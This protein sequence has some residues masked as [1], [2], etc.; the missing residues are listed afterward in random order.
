MNKYP[1]VT[2]NERTLGPYFEG[3]VFVWDIDKTYLDTHF[4]SLK[5]LS[6][7]PIEFAQDKKSV[8]GMPEILRGL[9]R[10]GEAGIACHPLYFVSASP[11]LLRSV[12]EHKMQLDGVEYDGF[13]FKDWP[14]ILRRLQPWRL[15]H[16][17]GF[18]VSAL[19]EGRLERP[20]STEYL[21]G[22]N[23]E[24][25][26]KALTFYSYIVNLSSSQDEIQQKLDQMDVR[27]QDKRCI[28][29]LTANLP[30]Q[31][32]T[33][34]GIYIRQVN[35]QK[36]SFESDDT[37]IY[38]EFSDARELGEILYQQNL[39]DELTLDQLKNLVRPITLK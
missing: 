24:M 31:R 19:L 6:R 30:L 33:V 18:K 39:V 4:S 34:K 22:D 20:M 16:Q 11:A 8:A 5:G 9:R 13:T 7:I 12:I 2:I 23:A 38:H 35:T 25:D 21:F 15:S 1:L 17:F 32:G 10:G 14:L 3:N 29:Q 37:D 28:L 27:Q 26:P 36:P